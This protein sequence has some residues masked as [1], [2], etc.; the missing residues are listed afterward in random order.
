MMIVVYCSRV[1]I[2]NCSTTY[3]IRAILL[4]PRTVPSMQHALENESLNEYCL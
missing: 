3:C 2:I 4:M 1:K